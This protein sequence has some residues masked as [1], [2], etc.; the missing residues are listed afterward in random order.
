MILLAYWLP[1]IEHIIPLK[2]ISTF[3][4]AGIFFFYGLK[5]S[6]KKMKEGLSNWKLH[7]LIQLTTF[8]IFPLVII[9]LF[10]FINGEEQFMIWLSVYF[11]ATL[12]SA[13]SAS[14]VMVSIAKGNVPGAIFNA[15]MSG[16]I[17]IVITPLWMGLFLETRNTSF[18]LG[19]IFIELII[20]ILVP[21]VLGFIMHRFWG[22][23]A[24]RHKKQLTV[25]DKSIIL[26][27]VYLSFSKSFSNGVFEEIGWI[28]LLFVGCGV[29]V[30]FLTIYLF[31][32]IISKKLNFSRE[33]RITSLFCGSKK[34]LIHGTVFSN[35]LFAS[36]SGASL[37]LIPLMIYHA[38]QLLFI[39]IVAERKSREILNIKTL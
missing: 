38:F 1:G 28:E 13:V 7:V 2:K 20:K 37:F 31:I 24:G 4:I 11:L 9:A 36:M 17:G 8:L 21:V 34:S 18:D 32:S 27:I 26:I 3:G 29:I 12:P 5:L 15:S 39:S 35:V 22:K 6:P 25:F 30:L 10:P 19:E 16:L 23:F 14:V 33:D